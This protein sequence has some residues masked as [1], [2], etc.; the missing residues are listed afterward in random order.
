MSSSQPIALLDSDEDGGGGSDLPELTFKSTARQGKSQTVVL[1]DDDDDGALDGHDSSSSGYA[2]VA[3]SSRAIAVHPALPSGK[4]RDALRLKPKKK[5]DQAPAPAALPPPLVFPPSVSK[6]AKGSK[7]KV[8]E[9]SDATDDNAHPEPAPLHPS[10]GRKLR[11]SGSTRVQ[12]VVASD[13]DDSTMDEADRAVPAA[14]A[15]SSASK[16]NAPFRERLSRNIDSSPMYSKT[17]KGK[18]KGSY[19]TSIVSTR[20]P[21]YSVQHTYGGTPQPLNDERFDSGPEDEEYE[22]EGKG[23]AKKSRRRARSSS[24]EN[25]DDFI[26]PDDV[27]IEREH[28]SRKERTNKGRSPPKQDKGKGKDVARLR[29][30]S[31]SSDLPEISDIFGSPGKHSRRNGMEKMQ[32]T[33]KEKERKERKKEK[34]RKRVVGSPE[35]TP[36]LVASSSRGR[37]VDTDSDDG[38]RVAHSAQPAPK[39]RKRKRSGTKDARGKNHRPLFIES[40]DEDAPRQRDASEDEDS[41]PPPKRKSKKH[42]KKKSKKS[43]QSSDS[44]SSSNDDSDSPAPPEDSDEDINEVENLKLDTD[45]VIQE[46]L[47]PK[48]DSKERK[49]DKLRLARAAKQSKPDRPPVRSIRTHAHSRKNRKP[50]SRHHRFG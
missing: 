1:S 39:S 34:H 16:N 9:D 7:H 36:E 10:N 46:K 50:S 42:K 5:R 14:A 24:K 29:E 35:P 37:A 23:T 8:V 26:V 20:V 49:L 6:P 18:V 17:F 13:D 33:R 38:I 28:S 32:S 21:L 47:R 40:E 11:K 48:D 15:R 31:A 44:G 3:T 45:Q 25:E 12:T 4:Q 27:P 41:P 2:V 43:V 30:A 22:S 19:S